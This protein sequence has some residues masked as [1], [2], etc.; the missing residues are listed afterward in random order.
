MHMH[1]GMHTPCVYDTKEGVGEG[2]GIMYA[3]IRSQEAVDG[4]DGEENESVQT[5]CQQ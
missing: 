4:T 2:T 3:P 1:A 5:S